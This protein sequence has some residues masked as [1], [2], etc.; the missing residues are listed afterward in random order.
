[1][2]SYSRMD[3]NTN[4]LTFYCAR[5]DTYLDNE[6]EECESHF[7]DGSVCELSKIDY[8]HKFVNGKKCPFFI[9]A[10]YV[11]TPLT[12]NTNKKTY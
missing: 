10:T 7:Q 11:T 8:S 5:C 12:L 3:K 1:M 6:N 9:F 4:L 2:F